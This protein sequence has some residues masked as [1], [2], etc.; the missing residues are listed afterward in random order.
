M[1]AKQRTNIAY[2]LTLST[3]EQFFFFS[4]LEVSYL[5]DITNMMTLIA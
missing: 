4:G 5:T 3:A 2:C 1:L